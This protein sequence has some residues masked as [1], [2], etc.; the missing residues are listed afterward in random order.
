MDSRSLQTHLWNDNRKNG[1]C[2]NIGQQR[3][4]LWPTT[5]RLFVCSSQIWVPLAPAFH[6]LFP[7]PPHHSIHSI[8]GRHQ[9][10]VLFLPP[11]L[12]FIPFINLVVLAGQLTSQVPTTP[13]SIVCSYPGHSLAPPPSNP[14]FS[15]VI[16]QKLR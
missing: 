8:S 11:H 12:H 2:Y 7:L 13:L 15:P 10:P 4:M 6:P 14:R 5:H 9:F 1:W 16:D 3:L